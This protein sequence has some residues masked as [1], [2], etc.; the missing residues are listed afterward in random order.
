VIDGL[1]EN[2]L[3]GRAE[4]IR[5]L[6]NELA[7]VGCPVILTTRREHLDSTFSVSVSL[8]ARIF[9]LRSSRRLRYGGLLCG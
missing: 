5:Q 4:G 8:L 9:C 6:S 2:R 7:E 3:Y 1:D